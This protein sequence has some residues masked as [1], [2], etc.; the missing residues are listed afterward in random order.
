MKSA[1]RTIALAAFVSLAFVAPALRA[2]DRPIARVNV[3]FSFDYGTTHFARGVYTFL[4]TSP[5]ILLIRNDA[6]AAIHAVHTAREP[7]QANGTS[8]VV[9]NQYGEHYFLEEVMILG[10]GIHITVPESKAE[11]NATR[12]LVLR[13]TQATQAAVTFLPRSSSGN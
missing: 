11:K 12:E 2:Q 9:F 13:G 7:V 10:S 8:R 1:I 5:D 3:P 4:M 6:D